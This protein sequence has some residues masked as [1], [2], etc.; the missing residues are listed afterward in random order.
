MNDI[1]KHINLVESSFSEAKAKH[2]GAYSIVP[3]EE[4]MDDKKAMAQEMDRFLNELFANHQE[5]LQK[6]FDAGPNM[7]R[8]EIPVDV[9]TN[10]LLPYWDTHLRELGFKRRKYGTTDIAGE[11]RSH[12][13]VHYFLYYQVR[14]AGTQNRVRVYWPSPKG[15]E[16]YYMV[17]VKRSSWPIYKK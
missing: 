10:E 5:Y 7:W 15:G 6:G 13:K 12:P 2:L 3:D 1:R 9:I 17:T 11:F 14:G 8:V 16:E 4:P